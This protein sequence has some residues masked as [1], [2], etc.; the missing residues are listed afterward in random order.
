MFGDAHN[1]EALVQWI[2]D[3]FDLKSGAEETVRWA[4]NEL[5]NQAELN[6]SSDIIVSALFHGLGLTVVIS[7]ALIGNVA[8]IQKIFKELFGAIG[9]GSGSVYGAIAKTMED[10]TH[11]WNKTIG[12]EEDKDHAQDQVQDNLNWFQRLFQKIK[13]F[14]QKIFGIFG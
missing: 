1:R 11:V 7:D 4:I 3:F 8:S 9:D 6:N 2:V 5:F 10:L 14:F 12:P 13:E